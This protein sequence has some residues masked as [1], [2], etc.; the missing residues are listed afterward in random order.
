MGV[1]PKTP[2]TLNP[3]SYMLVPIV[4]YSVFC[5]SSES[6]AISVISASLHTCQTALPLSDSLPNSAR[7]A[8]LCS[9]ELTMV[10]SARM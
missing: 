1:S 2:K 7:P 10:M 5:C 8:Q 6:L 9:D 4:R 3:V